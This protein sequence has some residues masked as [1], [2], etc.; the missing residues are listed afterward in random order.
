MSPPKFEILQS[1][2]K[3][4]YHV[5][6]EFSEKRPA[7]LFSENKHVMSIKDH[8]VLSKLPTGNDGKPALMQSSW[9][10]RE[11]LRGPNMPQYIED[12][13]Y[14]DIP[15]LAVHIVTFNDATIFTITY[16]HT[17]TDGMGLVTILRAWSAIL[18]GDEAAVPPFVGY[19]KTDDPLETLHEERPGSEYVLAKKMLKGWG[20]FVFVVRQIWEH[21]WW[22]KNESR[23]ACIPGQY[24]EELC[25]TARAELD[26]IHSK[27][28]GDNP[29]PFVSESDVLLSWWTRVVVRALNPS[30]SRTICLLNAFDS[31]SLLAKMGR[32]PV[33]DAAFMGNAVY[34]SLS[35]IPARD[36]CS[37][38]F[39][40]GLIAS[41]VRQSISTQRTVEQVQAQAAAIREGVE[42]TGHP[43]LYGD[44]GMSFLAYSNLH[45]GRLYE[46]DFSPAV[47]TPETD[48]LSRRPKSYRSGTPSF[49]NS[50][51]T[52]AGISPRG[53][54]IIVGKDKAGYWWII[55]CLREGAWKKI[56]QQ[57]NN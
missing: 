40:L 44:S 6:A 56:E 3:L 14:A 51:S 57:F 33:A 2:G 37:T 46:M 23:I 27:E 9:F 20:F 50:T 53:T 30:P 21:F 52:E 16:M 42:K 29:K 15:Q 36:F 55:A 38:S 8:S 49:V 54:G 12:W 43:P 24:V 32:S 11:H 10:F 41:Q 48:S 28:G 17:L 7:V 18:R 4:E 26:D 5:P 35:L 39:P 47:L 34:P 1:D 13:L 45:G 22:P 19:D 31:R 25:K